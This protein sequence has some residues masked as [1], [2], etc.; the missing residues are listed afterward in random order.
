MNFAIT[1]TT[2]SSFF[3]SVAYKYQRTFSNSWI[4]SQFETASY[5]LHR[6]FPKLFTQLESPP[7]HS[8]PDSSFTSQITERAKKNVLQGPISR[9][10]PKFRQVECALGRITSHS[11]SITWLM[12]DCRVTLPRQHYLPELLTQSL[13]FGRT[14]QLLAPFMTTSRAEVSPTTETLWVGVRKPNL[15]PTV[16][17]PNFCYGRL[18][19]IIIDRNVL[20]LVEMIG[21]GTLPSSEEFAAH[22]KKP[23]L[24]ENDRTFLEYWRNCDFLMEYV[25]KGKDELSQILL[26]EIEVDLKE[27]TTEFNNRQLTFTCPADQ[28]WVIESPSIKA[29]LPSVENFRGNHRIADHGKRKGAGAQSPTLVCLKRFVASD[30]DSSLLRIEYKHLKVS[31]L[32]TWFFIQMK[33]MQDVTCVFIILSLLPPVCL[34]VSARNTFF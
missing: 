9:I 4:E 13:T 17:T 23:K 34:T 14:R 31:F 32:T 5:S 8:I 29:F 28:V 6:N 1:G 11:P 16:N 15:L 27:V 20:S 7:I 26:V 21:E 12:K 19:K 30:R 18:K 22:C 25:S 24:A 33:H 2:D 3:N 10:F